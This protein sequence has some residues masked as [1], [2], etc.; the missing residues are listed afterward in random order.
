MI[1]GNDDFFGGMFDFNGDGRTDA[2]EAG[3]AASGRNAILVKGHGAL[4]TGMNPYDADAV[5]LVLEKE[6]I[7]A[8]YAQLVLGTKNLGTLDRVIQRLVYKM[9]YSKQADKK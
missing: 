4:C 5:K 3:K 7:A 1:W 8:M 2:V 6:A 9:K